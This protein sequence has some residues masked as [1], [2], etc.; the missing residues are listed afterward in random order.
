MDDPMTELLVALALGP[1]V[2]RTPEPP[3]SPALQALRR[4]W[5]RLTDRGTDGSR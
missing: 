3:P 5:A 4:L 1:E 2:K